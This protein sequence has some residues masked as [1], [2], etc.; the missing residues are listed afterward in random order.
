M[1]EAYVSTHTVVPGNWDSI[2][3]D[4]QGLLRFGNG[5]GDTV[6]VKLSEHGR[7]QWHWHTTGRN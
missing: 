2:A 5:R 3:Y 4:V 6:T 1:P 7:G